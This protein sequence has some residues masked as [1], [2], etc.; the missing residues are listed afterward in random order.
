MGMLADQYPNMDDEA[1][2]EQLAR[3]LFVAE[4]WGQINADNP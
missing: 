3:V 4:V 2:T 1:L